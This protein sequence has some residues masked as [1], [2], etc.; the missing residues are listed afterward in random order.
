MLNDLYCKYD[1]RYHGVEL[2]NPD[3]GFRTKIYWRT[4]YKPDAYH[5]KHPQDLTYFRGYSQATFGRVKQMKKC[6]P[7]RMRSLRSKRHNPKII[8]YFR[9]ESLKRLYRAFNP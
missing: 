9:R 1:Q 2:N 3:F 5:K 8:E 7:R 6:G 4:H